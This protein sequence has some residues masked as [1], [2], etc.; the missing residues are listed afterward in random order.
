MVEGPGTYANE[1]EKLVKTS[2]DVMNNSFA[3]KVRALF[4]SIFRFLVSA[5][6]LPVL[7]TFLSPAISVTQAQAHILRV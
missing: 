1:K 2:K 5:Q 3:T 6:L 7:V 4:L